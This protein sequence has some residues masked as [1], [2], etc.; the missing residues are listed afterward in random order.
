MTSKKYLHQKFTRISQ[1]LPGALKCITRP[2]YTAIQYIYC[3]HFLS[4]L[5]D[6]HITIL[7]TGDSHNS[8][9]CLYGAVMILTTDL[10]VVM[11]SLFSIKLMHVNKHS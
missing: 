2:K 6:V 11:L 1:L 4:K 5:D 9:T 3:Q 7:A 8:M 10:N